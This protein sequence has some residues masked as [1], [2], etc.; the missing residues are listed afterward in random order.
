MFKNGIKIILIIMIFILNLNLIFGG[1][2]FHMDT[3]S[4]WAKEYL[5]IAT[6]NNLV[7]EEVLKDLQGDITR[8]EFAE[9]VVLLYEELSQVEL[10][11]N[12]DNIFKDTNNDSVNKAYELGIVKGVNE[13]NFRPNEKI[14]RQEM[15]V[16][17][18][19]LLDSLH[20]KPVVDKRFIEFSDS[21]EIH[22]YA[23]NSI[24]LLYKLDIVKGVG[25][26]RIDPTGYT[27]R[28]Q[29]IVFIVRTF[30]KYSIEK[31]TATIVLRNGDKMKIKLLPYVAPNTVNNFI[32]LAEDGFYDG[33]KFDRVIENFMIQGGCPK[34]DGTG[35]DYKIKGEFSK[36]GHLNTLPHNRGTVSMA[37]DDFNSAGSMFFILSEDSNHLD[38][39]YAAFGVLIEGEDV[40]DKI[41]SART[42]NSDSPIRDIV[43]RTIEIERNGYNF[44]SVEKV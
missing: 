40:L 5:D 23:R 24:Q 15:V 33:T 38:G 26:N 10:E 25:E 2:G 17:L 30:N 18:N 29:S 37:R 9:L 39:S 19:R 7:T 20:I 34:G 44:A 27:T 32:Y 22:A 1:Q 11:Y 31:P 16:M 35:L 42:D 43:I 3:P 12:G 13:D 4:P 14:T 6:K 36:N 41:S 21:N 28:E 8:R